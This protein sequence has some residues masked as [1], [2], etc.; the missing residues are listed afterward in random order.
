MALGHRQK[1]PQHLPAN[2]TQGKAVF[3]RHFPLA[4]GRERLLEPLA[5]EGF[6]QQAQRLVEPLAARSRQTGWPTSRAEVAARRQSST[7]PGLPVAPE[8]LE[9]TATPPREGPIKPPPH[10]PRAPAR[11]SR[12][13]RAPRPL[14]MCR[15]APAGSD[16]LAR[17][18]SC[19]QPG[20]IVSSPSH[21]CV[22]PVTSQSKDSGC[23]ASSRP[24][25]GENR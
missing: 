5:D 2:E 7:G 8:R 13:E 22:Q 24:T 3:N 20:E 9:A 15:P 19:E 1:L 4:D 14:P 6:G 11:W 10:P 23:I 21:R 17:A 25:R 16:S 18:S 12:Y